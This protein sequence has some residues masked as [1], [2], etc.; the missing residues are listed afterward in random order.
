MSKKL[1]IEEKV[2]IKSGTC[3]CTLPKVE[4]WI[5][6]P[7]EYGD[8]YSYPLKDARY[9]PICGKALGEQKINGVSSN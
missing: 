7:D 1:C 8:K 3:I 9:C 6:T 5:V 2:A 4:L